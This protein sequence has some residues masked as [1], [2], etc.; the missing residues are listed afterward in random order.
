MLPRTYPTA[1]QAR[2]GLRSCCRPTTPRGGAR[3]LLDRIDGLLL[4]GGADVDPAPT[5]R[6]APGDRAH[7]ARARSLRD[8]PRPRGRRAR[9]ARA[10]RLPGHGDPERR[11]RRDAPAAPSRRDRQRRPP[12]HAGAFADHEVRSSRARSP[13]A[14]VG[15]ERG[16]VKSHHHQGVDEL[17]EGLSPP[18]GRAG[19]RRDRGDRAPGPSVRARRPLASRG[20]RAEPRDRIAGGRGES[21]GGCGVSRCRRRSRSS[22]PPPSR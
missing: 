5:A 21:R 8:R 2:A 22:S 15:A 19:G 9:D 4:A 10:R 7:L 3:P 1:V 17:G 20:G 14:A 6:A 12:P 13:P 11:P 18:A 16:A